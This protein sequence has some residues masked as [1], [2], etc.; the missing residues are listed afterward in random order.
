MSNGRLHTPRVMNLSYQLIQIQCPIFQL[1]GETRGRRCHCC[2]TTY[3]L[4]RT[5]LNESLKLNYQIAWRWSERTRSN[6]FA[7]HI[8]DCTLPRMIELV[9]SDLMDWQKVHEAASFTATETWSSEMEAQDNS[10]LIQNAAQNLRHILLRV[11]CKRFAARFAN[12]KY[13][14]Y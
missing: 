1:N 3:E 5:K 9:T 11:H 13:K 6:C 8:T 12:V 14:T 4:A 2:Y 7:L 10:Q